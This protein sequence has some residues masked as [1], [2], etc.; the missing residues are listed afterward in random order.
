MGG[1]P[2]RKKRYREERSSGRVAWR[3]PAGSRASRRAS[4]VVR[5]RSVKRFKGATSRIRCGAASSPK[6]GEPRRRR[7]FADRLRAESQ[8]RLHRSGAS[9]DARRARRLRLAHA[10]SARARRGFRKL[11]RS[12]RRRHLSR[13][14]RRG[15]HRGGDAR[16]CQGVPEG[17]RKRRFPTRGS[18]SFGP[19]AVPVPHGARAPR[20]RETGG[21]VLRR[22]VR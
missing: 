21:G 12:A 16:V 8:Q 19:R 11:P 9:E 5:R 1:P 17:K 13:V 10:R 3:R 14:A 15:A 6:K 22:R 18:V 4:N 7:L 20:P 2:E